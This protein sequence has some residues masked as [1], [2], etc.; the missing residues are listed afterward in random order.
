MNQF[1]LVEPIDR[2][3]QGIVVTVALAA[4][5]G[6]NAGFCQTLAVLYGYVLPRFNQSSQHLIFLEVKWENQSMGAANVAFVQ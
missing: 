6:L 1:S 3:G 2:L 4:H 5:R